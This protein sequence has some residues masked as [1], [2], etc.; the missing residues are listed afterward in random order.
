MN[1]NELIQLMKGSKSVV[2]PSLITPDS[3]P[4]LEAKYLKVP[5]IKGTFKYKSHYIENNS[6]SIP[7]SRRDLWVEILQNILN[8]ELPRE[9][10]FE[11]K[12]VYPREYFHEIREIAQQFTNGYFSHPPKH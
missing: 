7:F 1:R 5:F 8:E 4:E 9:L 3:I 10:N 6:I 12:N 11:G 2:F